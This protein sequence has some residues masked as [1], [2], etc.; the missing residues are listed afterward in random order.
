MQAKATAEFHSQFMDEKTKQIWA[1]EQERQ[2]WIKKGVDT[3]AVNNWSAAEVARIEAEFAEKDAETRESTFAEIVEKSRLR[4]QAVLE[5]EERKLEIKRAY[6]EMTRESEQ[7]AVETRAID[8]LMA[9]EENAA[10][11]EEA[12]D[13]AVENNE[14]AADDIFNIWKQTWNS[15][16]GIVGQF[17]GQIGAISSQLFANEKSALDN[18]LNDELKAAEAS[19]KNEEELAEEQDAIRKKFAKKEA[20]MRVTQFNVEKGL[21]LADILINTASAVTQALPNLILSGAIAA[22]GAI[23]FGLVAAQQPPPIPSF[24]FGG[25]VGKAEGLIRGQVGVDNN[26]IAASDGEFIVEKEAASR[27]LNLLEAIN[28]GQD[29]ETN[30][31]I[32]GIPVVIELDGREMGRGIIRF[33]ERESDRGNVRINPRASR[34]VI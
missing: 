16:S 34:T 21:R 33:L 1:I 17:A 10:I 24:R 32:E 4:V 6:W 28:R 26:L 29:P 20:E 31:T 14:K 13:T 25:P 27:N 2:A 5:E 15:I 12:L 3:V 9:M 7:E 30:I 11:E 23:Q 8:K 18:Q 19:I 22:L